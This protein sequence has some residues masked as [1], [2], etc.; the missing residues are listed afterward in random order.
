MGKYSIKELE[1]LSGIKAHTIRIWEKRHHLVAPQRTDTNIRYYSD[2]DLKKIIN[3]SALNNHGIKISKIVELSPDEINQQVSELS[4]ATNSNELYID[5]LVIAMIDLEE[6]QFDKIL[7]GLVLKFGFEK[8]VTE[9]I[10]PFL[11][12]IGIL[13]LT[14]HITPSQEHFISNLIRQKMLVA[15]DGLSLAP[16]SAP[17]AIFYLPE[18]EL[19]ELSLLFFHYLAKKTG[20]RTY[21]LGQSVP[22]KDLK[23]VVEQYKADIIVTALTS[24]PSATMMQAYLNRLSTEFASIK[25]FVT[26]YALKKVKPEYPANITFFDNALIFKELL[27]A[28]I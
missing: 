14:N 8:T 3:V 5:Q 20:L 27:N 19:H 13:W 15:I 1:K 11:E 23:S 18:N 22:F 24:G 4:N 12:K 2:E 9:I 16:K 26:G 6:E 25:I 28:S 7:S 10:Y 21:Y 17:K